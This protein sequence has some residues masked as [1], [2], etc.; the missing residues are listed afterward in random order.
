MNRGKVIKRKT[1]D[2]MNNFI[3]SERTKKEDFYFFYF[4][5]AILFTGDQ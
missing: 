4:K 1:D 2:R 5:F 3:H